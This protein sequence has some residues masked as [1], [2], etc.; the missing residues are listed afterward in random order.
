MRKNS[1]QDKMGLN[2]MSK[3]E[4]VFG[5]KPLISDNNNKTSTFKIDYSTPVASSSQFVEKKEC[6]DKSTNKD[7][8]KD[9][10]N[11]KNKIQYDT[12]MNTEFIQIQ[13]NFLIQQQTIMIQQQQ[14]MQQQQIFQEQIMQQQQMFVLNF[15]GNN[16][17]IFLN[18]DN[19]NKEKPI[20]TVVIKKKKI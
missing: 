10:V 16:N 11:N 1:I 12:Y 14:I 8:L 3:M 20:D 6:I 17:D 19:K 9:L 7:D 13:Q 4:T 2:F 15:N 18:K 5:G